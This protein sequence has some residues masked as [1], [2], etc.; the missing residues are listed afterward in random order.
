V[1]GC[2]FSPGQ[3]VTLTNVG[4]APLDIARIALGSGR[5]GFG[6]RALCPASLDTGQ[7][8]S[9]RIFFKPFQI[10]TSRD[11]VVITDNAA[12]SPQYVVLSAYATCTGP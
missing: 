2:I 4:G 8:C 11:D 12:D 7:S 6:D 9:I 5:Q 10:P 3:D 1:C